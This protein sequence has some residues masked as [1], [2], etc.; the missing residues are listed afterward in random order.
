MSA[1]I[2][3]LNLFAGRQAGTAL[4]QVNLAYLW[5][6]APADN[7][8]AHPRRALRLGIARSRP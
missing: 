1:G 3:A 5:P 8:W 2:T 4:D 6:K 7:R